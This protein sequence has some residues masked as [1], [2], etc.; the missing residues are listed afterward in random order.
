[1]SLRKRKPT[2]IQEQVLDE[3]D[4]ELLAPPP[5]RK[6]AKTRR[7][8]I[9]TRIPRKKED[10]SAPDKVEAEGVPDEAEPGVIVQEPEA[11]FVLTR[12]AKQ[13]RLEVP[14][15]AQDAD[16]FVT[17]EPRRSQRKKGDSP[18][19][20]TTTLT[21]SHSRELSADSVEGAE[22][23]G[24]STVCEEEPDK[25]KEKKGSRVDKV[26]KHLD[27][28]SEEEGGE[29]EAEE[30]KTA[31][32]KRSRTSTSRSKPRSRA[33]PKKTA[34]DS[35]TNPSVGKGAEHVDATPAPPASKARSR[36]RPKTRR[37]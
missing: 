3:D 36:P 31:S 21:R 17:P 2:M 15:I 23:A 12:D 26:I 6:R 27:K 32:A 11:D 24:S 25:E 18:A 34:S 10:S 4:D 7:T 28:N 20:S 22:S 13:E 8:T 16:E 14:A 35:S 33:A 19:S 37:R 5:P 30:V 29:D 1:M 9:S